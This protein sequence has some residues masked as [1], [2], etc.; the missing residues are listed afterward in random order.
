MGLTSLHQFDG[1]RGQNRCWDFHHPISTPHT[2]EQPTNKHLH[3]WTRKHINTYEQPQKPL[4]SNIYTNTYWMMAMRLFAFEH[5][6]E[7]GGVPHIHILQSCM[8]LF[9][10]GHCCFR[11]NAHRKRYLNYIQFSEHVLQ[12]LYTLQTTNSISLNTYQTCTI[13]YVREAFAVTEQSSSRR[14]S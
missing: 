7:R 10:F 6:A 4:T 13:Q 8:E 3:N 12:V 5:I 2:F 1:R 14:G 9:I 11:L